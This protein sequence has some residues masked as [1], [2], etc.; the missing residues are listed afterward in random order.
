MLESILTRTDC[1]IIFDY[2]Y[3]STEKTQS[4]TKETSKL[5]G[6]QNY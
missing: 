3:R 2:K 4:H 6:F 5:V 1:T